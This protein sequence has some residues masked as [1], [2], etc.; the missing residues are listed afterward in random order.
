MRSAPAARCSRR[1]TRRWAEAL[2]SHLRRPSGRADA[3]GERSAGVDGGEPGGDACAGARVR[4]SARKAAYVA[5]HSLGEYSALAAAGA[6]TMADA[7]RLLRTRGNAMQAAVPVGRRRDGGADRQGRCRV[8]GGER[9]TAPR[10][11]LRR[12]QRQQRRQRRDLGSKAGMDAALPNA[13]ERAHAPSPSTC[14]R[15]SIRR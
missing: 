4:C 11:R 7:A 2:A 12:R 5:G 6:L 14:P 1:W 8:G 9:R 3:D 13:K 10:R 15:R